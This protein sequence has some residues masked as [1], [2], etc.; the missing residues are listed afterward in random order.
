MKKIIIPTLLFLGFIYTGLI[1]A[2]NSNTLPAVKRLNPVAI[3]G[4][5]SDWSN[6]PSH[7]V[8]ED[9]AILTGGLFPV[10]KA[11]TVLHS[12]FYVQWDDRYLYLACNVA[13]N[14]LV[15][16]IQEG[17]LKDF[18]RTDSVEF[19]FDSRKPD[20]GPWDGIFKLAILPFDSNGHVQAVR[21]EDENPGPISEVA[22]DIK[23]AS[24]RTKQGYIIEMAIPFKYLIKVPPQKGM[25]FGFGHV[26]NNSNDPDAVNKEGQNVRENAIAWNP[27][28]EIW[29]KPEIW[30]DLILR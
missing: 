25:K 7:L 22:P 5:L 19:Y 2:Q 21:H 3:D 20:I 9:M 8:T 27:M 12:R 23:I 28:D 10:D 24:T 1:G 11:S 26:V 30:S 14:L 6:V 17:D 13:D 18:Y 29:T 4:K 15:N 16:N